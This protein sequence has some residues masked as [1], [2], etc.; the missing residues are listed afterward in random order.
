MMFNIVLNITCFHR[1]V[2][3][4]SKH[5]SFQQLSIRQWG[6]LW[7]AYWRL[8]PVLLRIKFKLLFGDTNWLEKKLMIA[9]NQAKNGVADSVAVGMHESVRLAA[10]LHFLGAECLPK[11]IVLAD[12]LCARGL[13]A[14]VV[15]GV[16][17]KNAVLNSHAWVELNG[18]MVAEPASV[19]QDF[20]A[21][22]R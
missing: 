2:L 21:L 6:W 18:L 16:S 20:I 3:K 13:S 1:S 5:N 22:K 19:Q 8:W 12:M 7:R 14:I 9:Q 17:K 15:I 11:S 4:M 10:R